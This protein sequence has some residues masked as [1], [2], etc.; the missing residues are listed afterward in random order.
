[1]NPTQQASLRKSF[2]RYRFDEAASFVLI[3][4]LVPSET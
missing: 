3:E 1:M 4:V 2:A